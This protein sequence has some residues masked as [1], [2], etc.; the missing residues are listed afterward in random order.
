[1]V[2]TPTPLQFIGPQQHRQTRLIRSGSILLP[3][4]PHFDAFLKYQNAQEPYPCINGH[5]IPLHEL[6]EVVNS[7][8]EIRAMGYPIDV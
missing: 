1:M 2:S 7:S 8:E 5:P 3:T 6:L 4:R